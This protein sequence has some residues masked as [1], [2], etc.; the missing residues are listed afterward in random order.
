[1]RVGLTRTNAAKQTCFSFLQ[2]Y[3]DDYSCALKR[4][5]ILLQ[6]SSHLNHRRVLDIYA[7]RIWRGPCIAATLSLPDHI[8]MSCCCTPCAEHAET[9]PAH[10]SKT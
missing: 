7:A 4:R 3:Q 8:F 6:V 9:L 1:M 10:F 2:V 5:G